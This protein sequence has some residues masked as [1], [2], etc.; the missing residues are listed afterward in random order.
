MQQ[1]AREV[2]YFF[3]SQNFSDGLR[4]TL[5]I[6]LPSL[7]FSFYDQHEIG[8]TISI[9]ALCVSICDAPGPVVHKR[10]GMLICNLSVFLVALLT[11]LIHQN[12]YLLG[13][14]ILIFSFFFSMFTVYGN[15]ASSI[16]TASLLIMVMMIDTEVG[17]HQL[18]SF[19]LL[20][21][22]GGIWYTLLSLSFFEIRPYRQAQ[23]ALGES[24]IAVAKF[25]EIK[26]D[27]YDPG[28]DA[29]ENY[30]KLISQQV[31]VSEKQDA[32][33]ELL[34]KSRIIV[35]ESTPAGRLLVL[36]FVDLVDM[37]EQIMATHYDY[38]TIREKFGDT[39]V[40][41]EIADAIKKVAWELNN[42]GFAI[43]ANLGYRKLTDFNAELEKLKIHIDA[44]GNNKD[45]PSNLML[46]KILINLR[47][48]SKRISDIDSYLKSKESLGQYNDNLK[49]YKRFVQ[50][51][52]Y[53]FEIFRNNLSLNSSS[54][55]HA[56]RVSLLCLAG[57]V[58]AKT[59]SLGHHSYWILLTIV[60]ILKPGFS[61]TKQRN[62][63]RIIG[64]LAGGLVGALILIF[65]KDKNAL[66]IILLIFML[67][68]YSFQRVNYI[69]T[70]F[71]M[72]PYIIL[73][74]KFL[75]GVHLGIIEERVIDTL[76]GSTIAFIGSYLIFP[77]WESE[78]LKKNMA[79][80]LKA[81]INYLI[82]IAESLSGKVIDTT[83]FKLARKDVYV[84]SANLS[85]AFQ[86]MT[87]EPRNKQRHPGNVHKFVV[88]N[89]IISSYSATIVSGLVKKQQLASD[90]SLRLLRRTIYILAES[91]KK[92]EPEAALGI[93]IFT[94]ELNET[95]SQIALNE[96]DSLLKEQLGFIQK[97]SSDIAKSTEI[98]AAN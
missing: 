26:A 44:L 35:K 37:F 4:I 51:Q 69:L 27:F 81:N 10:N 3:F 57:F 1:K 34:F 6:L 91:L 9:G 98:M 68:T 70:V 21:L 12:L 72:T 41:Q 87:S 29:D 7:I 58:I 63:Q 93:D 82:K 20:L 79:E 56:L 92:L 2:Q 14:E 96:D 46:K 43:Q 17:Q 5:G 80:A 32:V 75:G 33:R 67:G 59:I 86:R 31:L 23:Q 22:A 71:C 95:G 11:G 47:N 24:I 13:I 18:L 89:H 52:D 64:T 30:H 78:Q 83:E 94:G 90:D 39:G 54:F 61:L 55:K 19:C 8:L 84:S 74:F 49:E 62:Y 76:I 16:G 73:A 48:V 97:M 15:R 50:T 66:F 77:I 65:I 45:G 28:I 88:L 42:I 25:L 53:S 60:V 85:A 40:L 38:K 36:T